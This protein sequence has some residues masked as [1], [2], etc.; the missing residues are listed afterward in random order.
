MAVSKQDIVE[1]TLFGQGVPTITTIPPTHPYFA[2]EIVIAEP[3][4]AGARKLL[5]EAGY[6]NGLKL[7]VVVPVGRPVRE[8]LGITLQQLLKPAGF[9]LEIQRVPYSKYATEVVG[10]VPLCINGFFERPTIDASTFPFLHSKGTW[11]T[12]LWH[13]SDPKVDAALT[14][15]RSSGD[16]VVQRAQY[17]A[18]QRAFY[19]NPACFF[20]YSVNFACA[21]RAGVTGVKTHPMRWFDLRRTTVA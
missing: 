14:A 11:N 6:P 16:P 4:P 13:Y 1:L 17:V 9:D 8:R 20:A 3:D 18:M 15:A 19:E 5:A 7:P 21:Y 12:M 10:K 2:H